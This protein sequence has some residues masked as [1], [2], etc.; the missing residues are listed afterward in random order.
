MKCGFLPQITKVTSC[1]FYNMNG[2]S[3]IEGHLSRVSLLFVLSNDG[4]QTGKLVRS[5]SGFRLGEVDQSVK[6]NV[7]RLWF[8]RTE[9][10]P[11]HTRSWTPFT[12]LAQTR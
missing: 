11:H 6:V 4:T 2:I 7:L 8:P 10:L 5:S 9:H 3:N 1:M 12:T